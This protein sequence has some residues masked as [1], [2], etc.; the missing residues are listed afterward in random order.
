MEIK[1]I[2]FVIELVYLCVQNIGNI[3]LNPDT[4]RVRGGGGGGGEMKRRVHK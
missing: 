1:I 4:Q 3:H 2:T